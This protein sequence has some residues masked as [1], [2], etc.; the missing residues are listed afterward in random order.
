MRQENEAIQHPFFFGTSV[1]SKYIFTDER[2][3]TF[4]DLLSKSVPY[5]ITTP[6]FTEYHALEKKK[7]Q[8]V[9]ANLLKFIIPVSMVSL[10]RRAEFANRIELIILDIDNGKG[11]E[12]VELHERLKEKDLNHWIYTT[13]SHTEDNPKYRVIVEAN[14]LMTPDLYNQCIIA[15]TLILGLTIG[16]PKTKCHVDSTSRDIVHAMF[17]PARFASNPEQFSEIK[18]SEGRA[19]S[20]KDIDWK[21]VEEVI[22]RLAFSTADQQVISYSQPPMEDL[23]R[24]TVNTV[25][26][27]ISHMA[28]EYED[29]LKV[30][31][32]LHHQY[33]GNDEGLSIWDTWSRM[34]GEEKY[35]KDVVIEKWKSFSG[36][37][38]VNLRAITF[39]SCFSWAMQEDWKPTLTREDL[40]PLFLEIQSLKN[41]ERTPEEI[42][43][44]LDNL[45]DRIRYT[46]MRPEHREELVIEATALA[47]EYTL[48]FNKGY[49]QKKFAYAN[50]L[51]LSRTQAPTWCKDHVFIQTIN[52][53]YIPEKG[54]AVKEDA[55]NNIFNSIIRDSMAY[56]PES[57]TK[58]TKVKPS[59][60]ERALDWYHI[61][62]VDDIRFMP[63]K[64]RIIRENG[65]VYLNSFIKPKYNLKH[66]QDWSQEEK[67]F[68]KKLR[69][70]FTWM[71]PSHHVQTF[72][73][74]LATTMFEPETKIRW[75]IFMHSDA[76][77][78]GK[79]LFY[80]IC[81]VTMGSNLISVVK[82][83]QLVDLSSKWKDSK[84][85]VIVEEA[86]VDAATLES[87]KD[88]ISNDRMVV[89]T[90]HKDAVE[91]ENY[92][93]Y[94]FISNHIDGLEI[95]S[96]KERRYYVASSPI[97]NR[98]DMYK[99]LREL[100][101]PEEEIMAEMQ[102]NLEFGVDEASVPEDQQM[103]KSAFSKYIFD[104]LFSGIT[105]YKEAVAGW[106]FYVYQKNKDNF[107][108]NSP[109]LTEEFKRLAS[110]F[111]DPLE[112]AID[113]LID[114]QLAPAYFNQDYI[115][116]RELY[117]Y[118][119]SENPVFKNYR[120]PDWVLRKYKISSHSSLRSCL[121]RRFGYADVHT[122]L[123]YEN[124]ERK[125]ERILS[126]NPN[127]YGRIRKKEDYK[128]IEA[129]VK[130]RIQ[131][132]SISRQESINRE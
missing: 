3:T 33:G 109:K 120:V 95:K 17:L 54:Y 127:F 118:I 31:M 9:K 119:T 73:T 76:H 21:G 110:S 99:R 66:K 37:R 58:S 108:C 10:Q 39:R 121:I 97:R 46:P 123:V 20:P 113:D 22:D 57:N 74:F 7:Q 41:S 69:D 115:L 105:K 55:Y 6:S 101:V 38:A 91:V 56:D 47:K 85:L 129:E 34:Y 89:R 82:S 88:D 53:I 45:A 63:G 77:G 117:E 23:T 1:R 132:Q 78:I 43:I 68:I 83:K 42:R 62:K 2:T 5:E 72:L 98:S 104:E 12:I 107:D 59:P 70:H 94:I 87:L 44:E 71:F 25:L 81:R 60:W 16:P 18:Y 24:E 36:H 125:R 15:V 50:V 103:T 116:V 19:F 64:P 106:M 13:I 35:D 124:G 27:Q 75:S 52:Q 130:A 51:S 126:K 131:K 84:K 48:P 40:T 114:D 86:N 128:R 80:E 49:F 11:V 30:G 102:R 100:N 14:G 61:T 4:A 26:K 79:S 8:E 122:F 93:N 112:A 65:N 67:E 28:I 29:W 96:E 92:V 111:A 32:A 90:M